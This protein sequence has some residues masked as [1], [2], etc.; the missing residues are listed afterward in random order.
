ML[1]YSDFNKHSD[2]TIQVSRPDIVIKDFGQ[3]KYYLININP[4]SERNISGKEFDKPFKYKRLVIEITKI[5]HLN[6]TIMTVVIGAPVR[7]KT[8]TDRYI[9]D[10]P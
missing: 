7:I 8:N 5:W 10:L 2:N 6:L 9:K 4:S 3:G 1:F